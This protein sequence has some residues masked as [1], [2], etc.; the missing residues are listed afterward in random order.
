[1][2]NISKTKLLDH[3]IELPPKQLQDNFAEFMHTHYDMKCKR[4]ALIAGQ[5]ST[6]AALVQRAFQG[7]L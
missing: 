6:F 3:L 4:L 1:M 7:E 2:P 5:G